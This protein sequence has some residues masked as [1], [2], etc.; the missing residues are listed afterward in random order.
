MTARRCWGK[1][2]RDQREERL[3]RLSAPCLI[4]DTKVERILRPPLAT[5]TIKEI[6][7]AKAAQ[8]GD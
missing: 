4:D 8:I 3:I 5:A 7:A 1:P 6:L 2:A